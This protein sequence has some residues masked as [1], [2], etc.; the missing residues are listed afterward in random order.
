M[1]P[2]T[3]ARAA[4]RRL[5]TRAKN[6]GGAPSTSTSASS[7]SSSPKFLKR[8]KSVPAAPLAL[9][10]ATVGTALDLIHGRVDVLRYNPER[11][12]I[13]WTGLRDAP[14]IGDDPTSVLLLQTSWAV[15]I[16]LASFYVVDAGLYLVFCKG[17][18][19]EPTNASEVAVRLGVLGML[20]QTSALLYQN[21]VPYTNIKAIL[22][23]LAVLN[24][25]SFDK[26][27]KTPHLV[28]KINALK[29]AMLSIFAGVAAPLI[30]TVL[31]DKVHLW[32]YPRPDLYGPLGGGFPSW[33]PLCYIFYH[34]FLFSLAS[35]LQGKGDDDSEDKG[36]SIPIRK[37]ST[38]L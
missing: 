10:G 7:S 37:L 9:W 31:I 35:Y 28:D 19:E 13:L 21:R 32:S 8:F 36:K 25:V 38:N 4:E 1:M 24:F 29:A 30:E 34:P 2:I 22:G 12:G 16:L 14:Q 20:L 33:V 5:V 15:P 11:G 3:R 18:N 17:E 6:R 27:L 26:R 23:L